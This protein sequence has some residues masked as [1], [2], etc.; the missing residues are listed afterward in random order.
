M[1]IFKNIKVQKSKHLF[2]C[3]TKC[4]SGKICS[5]TVT[6]RSVHPFVSFNKPL[7]QRAI[8]SLTRSGQPPMHTH[9]DTHTNNDTLRDAN[10]HTHNLDLEG[11][12]HT[13]TQHTTL[14][15][16]MESMSSGKRGSWK[17]KKWLDFSSWLGWR[18]A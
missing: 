16:L 17:K 4:P 2:F 3:R 14:K 12:T 18:R 8:L 5:S 7:S 10:T 1:A 13:H 15:S 9:T 11:H 6:S